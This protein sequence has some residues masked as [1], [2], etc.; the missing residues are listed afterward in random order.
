MA[1]DTDTREHSTLGKGPPVECR[2][3]YAVSFVICLAAAILSRLLPWRW[4]ARRA[5]PEARRSIVAEARSAA[6][7]M[8]PVS[9]M[10]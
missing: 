8:I 5:R 9:F 2:V 4:S 3:I 1:V 10:G 6:S 7:T